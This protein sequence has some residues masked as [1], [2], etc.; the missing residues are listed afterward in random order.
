M[1]PCRPLA[2]F[3][4]KLSNADL[5]GGRHAFLVELDAVDLLKGIRLKIA[6]PAMRA[7]D[8]GNVFNNEHFL[9]LP[10]GS[11]KPANTGPSFAQISPHLNTSLAL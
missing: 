4:I 10:I 9:P 8:D 1:S 11:R 5:T 6:F 7:G 2:W 3:P